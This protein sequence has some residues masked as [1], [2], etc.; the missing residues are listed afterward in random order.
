MYAMLTTVAPECQELQKGVDANLAF[1]KAHPEAPP[2][3]L[4][5]SSDAKKAGGTSDDQADQNRSMRIAASPPITARAHS[6]EV[7]A[8]LP[9]S[10]PDRAPLTPVAS[11]ARLP[12]EAESDHLLD[13]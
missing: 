9:G 3:E 6:P 10:V 13:V 11:P 12:T 8:S 2:A 5:P 1:W 4:M 7:E